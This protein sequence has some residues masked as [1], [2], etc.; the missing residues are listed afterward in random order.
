M[1]SKWSHVSSDLTF[2]LT[3]GG[4]Y[5]LILEIRNPVSLCRRSERIVD[6]RS[7]LIHSPVLCGEQTGEEKEMRGEK[8]GEVRGALI[9]CQ[10]AWAC[11]SLAIILL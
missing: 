7:A 11:W 4:T 9:S 8:R 3:L 10:V 1:W 2:T 5:G 6:S